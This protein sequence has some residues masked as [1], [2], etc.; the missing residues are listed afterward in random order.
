MKINID[1]HQVDATKVDL[2]FNG[3]DGTRV[4]DEQWDTSRDRKP[5]TVDDLAALG[6]A[7]VGDQL[8]DGDE[9]AE[10]NE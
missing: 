7:Y 8:P 9:F 2:F 1:G 4:T 10:V 5:E 6:F 3:D